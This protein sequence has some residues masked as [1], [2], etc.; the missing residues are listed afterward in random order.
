M[1][2]GLFSFTC[3]VVLLLSCTNRQDH[4]EVWK[5]EIRETEEHFSQMAAENGIHDAFMAFAADDVTILRK[6]SL[7][8]GKQAL[9]SFYLGSAKSRS[10][11]YLTWSPDFVDV[12]ASGDL[13]YTYGKYEFRSTDS[14]GNTT[15]HHGIF[16]TVWKRQKNGE[17]KFVWD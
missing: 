15:V 2:N 17:W 3:L 9:D 1:K 6:D 10:K 16:H 11:T 5:N 7:L 4:A 13:G 12:S 14:T 8:K